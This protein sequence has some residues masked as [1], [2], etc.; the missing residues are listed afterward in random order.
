[1]MN[2]G[3]TV[4]YTGVTSDLLKRMYEHKSRLLD[5]FTKKYRV[6]RLVYYEHFDEIQSAILREKQ[7]KGGSRKKEIALSPSA[8]RND[9]DVEVGQWNP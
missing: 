6:H 4:I 3:K 7:I 8:P 2:D 9:V 1:M 5:G